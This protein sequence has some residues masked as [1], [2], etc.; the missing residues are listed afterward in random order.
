MICSLLRSK[1]GC[2]RTPNIFIDGRETWRLIL[3]TKDFDGDK[4][5]YTA[6]W[7]DD[8]REEL[9][10]ILNNWQFY[11]A[12]SGGMSFSFSDDVIDITLASMTKRLT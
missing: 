5:S 9:Q 1:G 6:V 2:L 3:D 8:A 11:V 10:E 12:S 4:M 7:T